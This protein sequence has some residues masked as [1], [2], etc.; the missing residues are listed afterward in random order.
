MI[1]RKFNIKSMAAIFPLFLS[2]YT[3]DSKKLLARF[4][5]HI[6]IKFIVFVRVF[7]NLHRSDYTASKRYVLYAEMDLHSYNSNKLCMNK[8]T[9]LPADR[10]GC[11]PPKGCKTE[12]Q[13]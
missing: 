5:K 7:Y 2:L 12:L 11:S 13:S 8:P 10:K 4:L 6:T 9:A 3:Y 1:E